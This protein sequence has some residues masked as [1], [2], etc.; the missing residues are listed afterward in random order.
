VHRACLC[1][2][3]AWPMPV[4]RRIA[5]ALR[6]PVHTAIHA[7]ST[8]RPDW[9]LARYSRLARE[10]GLDGP[11][12]V[13]S[14]DCDTDLDIEV[15][16]DVHTRLATLG[17][18]PCYAVPGELL[19][20]GATVYQRIAATGAE[21]LN[22]GYRTHTFFH[23]I[24]RTYEST[25]FYDRLDRA[26]IRDDI[27]RGHDAHVRVLGR[28]PTGFRVPHFGTY[29]ELHQLRLLHQELA[30]LGYRYSSSTVPRYGLLHG[31][32]KKS[33]AGIWEIAVSGCF[34]RPTTIL[35][36]WGVRYA[37]RRQYTEEDYGIQFGKMLRFFENKPGLLNYY[38]DP[39]QVY[40]WP[41]FFD[42]IAPAAR[43]AAD[44]FGHILDQV[45][46]AP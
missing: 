35:D 3:V 22:H 8:R 15:A 39:S 25:F 46:A 12:F 18:R 4:A 6:H 13:L 23:P 40:D 30:E 41:G 26:Q 37:E 2:S 42:A 14:F 29:Q 10:Q 16:E 7:V 11:R 5:F 31:P 45:D 1:Y 33:D 34:D 36:S 17:I 21:F 27:R 43:V 9:V 38:A 20:R 19:E 32:L 28:A 24:T 44:S